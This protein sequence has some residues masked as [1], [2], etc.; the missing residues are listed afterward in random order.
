[1]ALKWAFG[2]FLLLSNTLNETGILGIAKDDN[3]PYAHTHSRYS[4][5]AAFAF[6]LKMLVIFQISATK[7]I[8]INNLLSPA[9]QNRQVVSPL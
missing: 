2:L 3:T 8:D 6:H 1:M 9:G 7:Y 5:P 4:T